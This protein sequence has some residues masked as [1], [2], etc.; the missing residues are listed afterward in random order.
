[1][2]NEIEIFKSQLDIVEVAQALN[3]LPER[4]GA[5]GYHGEE[6]PEKCTLSSPSKNR[7]RWSINPTLQ[8]GKCWH[9]NT[10]YDVIALVEKCRRTNFV[11]AVNYLS[12]HFN[13]P[14]PLRNGHKRSP[15][16]EKAWA[17]RLQEQRRT[18][19]IL[20]AAVNHCHN[21][22][23]P[24]IRKHL[25]D[26]YGLTDETIDSQMI[27]YTADKSGLLP[28]LHDQGYTTKEVVRAGL[29]GENENGLY[30]KF[31]NRIIFPY[32]VSGSVV[33]LIGRFYEWD[34]KLNVSKYKKLPNSEFIENPIVGADTLRGADVCYIQE[35]IT[36]FLVSVQCGYP[37]LSPATV[38]FSHKDVPKLIKILRG[39]KKVYIVPDA[40]ENSAGMNGAIRTAQTLEAAG[41]F[42][43]IVQ[44]PRP[45][46]VE[47][48][49]FTEFI[50]DHGKESFDQ[51]VFEAK[52]PLELKIDEIADK[53][54]D[55]LELGE[56]LT[57][58]AKDLMLIPAV[59]AET[60]LIVI[61]ERLNLNANQISALRKQVRGS[62][63]KA[64]KEIVAARKK[65][66][67][68]GQVA[69][70]IEKINAEYAIVQVGG[71]TTIMHITHDP[72][73]E[74]KMEVFLRK[75][76]FLLQFLNKQMGE[77]TLGEEWLRDPDRREYKGLIFAP[78]DKCPEGYYNLW[79]G[80]A[81]EP[82]QGDWRKFAEHTRFVC[83]NDDNVALYVF[84]WMAFIVQNIGQ[85]RPE[86]AFVMRGKQGTGKGT[87]ARPFGSLF[88]RAF[89]HA[90][91]MEH[92]VGRFNGHLKNIVL[93]FADEALWAGDRSATGR[94]KGLI[95]E[96]TIT[97]EA[98]FQDA[99]AVKNNIS[100]IIATNNEWA[101]PA[102]L[103]DRRLL[104]VDVPEDHANEAAYFDEINRQMYEEGG[105]EA[106]LYDLLNL[107]LTGFNP[108][109]VPKTKALF[110]QKLRS[111]EPTESWVYTRL[112]MGGGFYLPIMELDLNG[113]Y[114][115]TSSYDTDA[116]WPDK[117]NKEDLYNDYGRYFDEMGFGRRFSK[118]YIQHFVRMS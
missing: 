88:G 66:A 47:K 16:E 34:P 40:E 97:I 92:V 83:T 56:E 69:P 33:Y 91:S 68:A 18:Y 79:D 2:K 74:R 49:D 89:F 93:L 94:F 39:I 75:E 14:N 95:T 107:D 4:N 25:N 110:D 10:T 32:W 31:H 5:S 111:M 15:E 17:D 81:V 112:C 118:K 12:E 7:R 27:G 65:T 26:H 59:Q 103:D 114:C 113:S 77:K 53:K 85:R 1:M 106:M 63:K 45:D 48:V 70:E 84:K 19:K 64:K 13:V 20:G 61:K 36:D 30:N 42:P 46:G 3:V 58:L 78:G 54:L 90:T 57:L 6:C 80:F 86:T 116:E 9:C 96:P 21:Y 105:R 24:H 117:I 29:F 62:Q 38:T 11:G 104:V 100:T 22:L 72:I 76:D 71:R 60:Y 99:F 37:S 98:K 44:L 73:F 52:R 102:D 55:P 109:K 51:L 101:A 82:K 115:S 28:Y 50:S 108:T 23:P 35:G 41:C 8:I 67:A 43:L 87:V